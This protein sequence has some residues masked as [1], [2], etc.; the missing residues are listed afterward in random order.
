MRRARREV[1]CDPGKHKTVDRCCNMCPKGKYVQS[2]CQGEG[3]TACSD[4]PHEHFMDKEN[5]MSKCRPCKVCQTDLHLVTAA[6]CKADQDR[7]CKCKEGFYCTDQECNHCSPVTK[8]TRGFGVTQRP[9]ATNDT[10]CE[11]CPRGTFSNVSNYH[12]PC[13]NHTK[14]VSVPLSVSV[15]SDYPTP[16]QCNLSVGLLAG[17]VVALLVVIIV[18]IYWKCR[19]HSKMTVNLLDVKLEPGPLGPLDKELQYPTLCHDE[20]Y[21]HNTSSAVP[22]RPCVESSEMEYDCADMSTLMLTDG[23]DMAALGGAAPGDLS[24]FSR[25]QLEPQENEWSET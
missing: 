23:F 20:K 6:E 22:I 24:S 2:E 17:F 13:W 25:C 16:C 8:C 3:E 12:T 10:K 1:I 9:T 19:R 7:R 14:L 4:C 21:N 18:Y 11:P 15:C 5:F